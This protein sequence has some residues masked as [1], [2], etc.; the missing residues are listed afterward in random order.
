MSHNK[1]DV[2]SPYRKY[3]DITYLCHI[4]INMQIGTTC[5]SVIYA[6]TNGPIDRNDI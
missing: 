6:N 1:V 3:R 5:E 4:D 2:S